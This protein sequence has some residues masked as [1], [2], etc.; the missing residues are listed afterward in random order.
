MES[1]FQPSDLPR[2]DERFEYLKLSVLVQ[3]KS[4]LTQQPE[5]LLGQHRP[6]PTS[7]HGLFYFC[8]DYELYFFKVI[9]YTKYTQ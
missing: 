3:N 7:I 9:L 5:P 8:H 2:F 6:H 4:E 1:Q